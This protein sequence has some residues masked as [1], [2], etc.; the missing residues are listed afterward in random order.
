[1]GHA[2]MKVETKSDVRKEY[3]T[4]KH[5]ADAKKRRER[6]FEKNRKK[7]QGYRSKRSYVRAIKFGKIKENET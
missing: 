5:K 1:M 6:Q 4:N 3:T 7:R 2:K